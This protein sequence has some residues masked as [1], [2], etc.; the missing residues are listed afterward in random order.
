MLKYM[1]IYKRNYM[2]IHCHSCTCTKSATN[3]QYGPDPK[4]IKLN[5]NGSETEITTKHP[6]Y[7]LRYSLLSRCYNAKAS[8]YHVYQGRGIIVCD[9]WKDNPI[10][11]YE[12]CLKNG[13]RKGITIDRVD[14]S[15]NYE[16]SNCQ[17]L[18]PAENTRKSM[19][20]SPKLRNAKLDKSKAD[21]IRDLL[22]KGLTGKEI[23]ERFGVCK[24]T[25]YNIKN[26]G[27]WS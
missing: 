8:E 16:P 10:A 12:W 20:Q 24:S 21:E 3:R 15:G 1:D 7:N 13:W 23:A 9:E 11:F 27:L 25:I 4:V 18:T 17:F 22:S 19:R 14:P 2:P 26:H 6:L 5:V